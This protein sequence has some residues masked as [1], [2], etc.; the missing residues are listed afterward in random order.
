MDRPGCAL[1]RNAYG[2]L[3]TLAGSSRASR[4]AVAVGTS[5]TP[6]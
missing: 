3:S 2:V 5:T 6:S 4:A 1:E